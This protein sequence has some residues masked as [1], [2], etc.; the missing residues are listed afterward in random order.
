MLTVALAPG[1]RLPRLQVTVP[2][3]SP[4][5]GGVQ[6]P[7]LGVADV[8]VTPAGRLSVTTTPAAV[9]GPA[10]V[11]VTVYVSVPFASTGSGESVFVTERSACG[12]TMIAGA[13]S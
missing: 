10:L 9:D 13:V 11:T 1:A 6:V 8:N 7:W 3:P 4:L 12:V 2:P 5:A